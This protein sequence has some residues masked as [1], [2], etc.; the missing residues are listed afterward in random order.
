MA[1]MMALKETICQMGPTLLS[2]R[3]MRWQIPFAEPNIYVQTKL[4]FLFEFAL[5]KF[6]ST[7]IYFVAVFTFN[8]FL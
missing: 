3:A 2:M 7:K 6:I 4:N 1:W 8:F 5:D